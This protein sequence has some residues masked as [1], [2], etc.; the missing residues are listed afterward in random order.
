MNKND[1]IGYTPL[2]RASLNGHLEV[3]RALLAAGADVNKSDNYGATPLS[4][5][6]FYNHT[7]IADLLRDAGAHEPAAGVFHGDY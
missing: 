5:A 1:S 7:Q 2:Y 3:V 6:L 4:R